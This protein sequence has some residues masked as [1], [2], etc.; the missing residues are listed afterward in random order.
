MVKTIWEKLNT[1]VGLIATCI[2]LAVALGT[3]GV[4]TYK[5]FAKT[6]EVRLVSNRVTLNDLASW[7]RQNR[8]EM[9]YLLN[10]YG[11]VP[12]Q[13]CRMSPADAARYQFLVDDTAQLVAEYNALRAYLRE[14]YGYR[15]R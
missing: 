4:T 5:H 10:K 11:C 1:R 2:G 13:P 3:G 12:Q 6:A 15:G 9:Q 8:A 14:H 7:I